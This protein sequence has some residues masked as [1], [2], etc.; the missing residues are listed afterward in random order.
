[1]K[2]GDAVAEHLFAVSSGLESVVV[3]EG[4][5]AGQVRRA[6]EGARTGGTT[7]TGLERLFQTD[8]QHLARR[9]EPARA[10]RAPGDPWSA[11]RSTSPRAASPTGRPPASSGRHGRLRRREPRGAP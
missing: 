7:S 11:S 6:L 4:E 9:Q 8:V 5:I 10:C 2:C 3:G 1:M